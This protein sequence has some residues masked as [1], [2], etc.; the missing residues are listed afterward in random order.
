LR[1][2][3]EDEKMKIGSIVIECNEF[4]EM[5]TFWQEALRYVPRNPPKGCW[6]VLVTLKEEILMFL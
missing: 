1:K 6:V 4:E 5:L 2:K 3:G